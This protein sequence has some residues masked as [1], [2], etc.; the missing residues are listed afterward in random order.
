MV[1]RGTMAEYYRRITRVIH[2]QI[3]FSLTETEKNKLREAASLIKEVVKS[4][5]DYY[6]ED[7]R[8]DVIPLDTGSTSLLRLIIAAIE[9]ELKKHTYTHVDVPK[10]LS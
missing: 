7:E 5:D 3:E 6:R 4:V 10:F 1:G 8:L 2:T 9:D